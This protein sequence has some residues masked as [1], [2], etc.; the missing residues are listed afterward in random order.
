MDNL[1]IY[2]YCM[3]LYKIKVKMCYIFHHVH[4]CA[5]FSMVIRNKYSS[6]MDNQVCTILRTYIFPLITTHTDS[7]PA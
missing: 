2:I 4:R 6:T 5:I 7:I 3:K 1:F